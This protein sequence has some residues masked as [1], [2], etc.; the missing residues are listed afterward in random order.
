MKT[1]HIFEWA[2]I[3]AGREEGF[4]DLTVIKELAEDDEISAAE[5]GFM[6]GYLEA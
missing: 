6:S 5:E 2:E 1:K 4:Y 3:D